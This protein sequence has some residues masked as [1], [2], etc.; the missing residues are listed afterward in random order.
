MGHAVGCAEQALGSDD[1]AVAVM[2]PDD[3]VLPACVM[4]KMFQVRERLG[5]SVLC[6]FNVS[7]DEMSNY[8]VFDVVDADAAF[9]DFDVLKV[10]DMVEKPAVEDAPSTLVA[11]GRHLLDRGIFDA[12]YRIEP[13][14][15]GE[16]QLTDAI[17]LMISEGHS[18]HVVVHE[19]KRHDLGNPGG[20]IPTNV[21][22]GLR[23]ATYGSALY[24]ALK[25]IIALMLSGLD[26]T[27]VW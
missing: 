8:S 2:L 16:L 1:D 13:R 20:Y 5:G 23:D 18:V 15:G 9:D 19:D 21:D 12:L 7:R 17:E 10:R 6:A 14:K 4:D 24:S 25:K 11:T 22:F 3:L 26:L 27:P